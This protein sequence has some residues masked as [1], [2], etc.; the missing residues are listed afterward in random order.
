MQRRDDRRQDRPGMLLTGEIAGEMVWTQDDVMMI[1]CNLS[2][3][4]MD[5]GKWLHLA[6]F[7]KQGI[8]KVYRDHFMITRS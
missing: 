8:I 2:H 6:V 5:Y 1:K 4:A 3:Y 7:W